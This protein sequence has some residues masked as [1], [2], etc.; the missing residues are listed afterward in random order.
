MSDFTPAEVVE[1]GNAVIAALAAGL[2]DQSVTAT[3][4]AKGAR[5]ALATFLRQS[6]LIQY[7]A[8]RQSELAAQRA[9]AAEEARTKARA[10]A[11]ERET[12]KHTTVLVAEQRRQS[13]IKAAAEFVK[14]RAK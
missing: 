5:D 12:R 8:K 4:A 11:E 7:E 14:G 9:K 3:M 6:I 1:A 2:T 10:A 13:E